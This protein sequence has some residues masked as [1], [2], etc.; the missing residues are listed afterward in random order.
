MLDL[1]CLASYLEA[2][3]EE[4]PRKDLLNTQSDF[5]PSTLKEKIDTQHE[6]VTSLGPTQQ[7]S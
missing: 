4:L 3:L 5:G 6:L 1:S 7:T 2:P